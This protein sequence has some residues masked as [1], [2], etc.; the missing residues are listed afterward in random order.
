MADDQEPVLAA[1]LAAIMRSESVSITHITRH[2][3]LAHNVIAYI[4]SGKTRHPKPR[5][6]TLIAEAV[7][8]DDYTRERDRQKMREIERKL[9]VGAGYADPSAS[10]A[11]SLLEMSLYYVLAS[12]ERARAWTEVIAALREL[13]PER[14]RAL[15]GLV[16]R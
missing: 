9:A 11:R 2:S 16:G 14:V 12:G 6:L 15:P 13:P 1:T 5:T 10:E 4:L 3:G 8:T 7:A